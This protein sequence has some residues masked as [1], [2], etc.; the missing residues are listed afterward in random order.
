MSEQVLMEKKR[1]ACNISGS[2]GGNDDGNIKSFK[3]KQHLSVP[4]QLMN[5][6]KRVNSFKSEGFK[7]LI[8]PI[9]FPEQVLEL[10]NEEKMPTFNSKGG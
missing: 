5:L 2:T 10:V 1:Q 4:A 9:D 8:P 7:H 3:P 6:Y